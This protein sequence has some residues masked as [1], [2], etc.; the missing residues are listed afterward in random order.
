[1]EGLSIQFQSRAAPSKK[2][3]LMPAERQGA[4]ER[5]QFEGK[6]SPED[7]GET[8]ASG[9]VGNPSEFFHARSRGVC[10]KPRTLKGGGG[11]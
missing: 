7:L 5:N 11:K 6:R 1:M 9:R 8:P 3:S 4:S 2:D 10:R